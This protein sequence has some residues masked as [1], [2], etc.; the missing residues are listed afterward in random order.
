MAATR[1]TSTRGF[2]LIELVVVVAV[3]AIVTVA[4]AAGVGNI[5][6]ASVQSE[7]GKIAIAVRYLYNLSVLSGKNH[8]LVIDLDTQSYW[9]ESQTTSDP[10]ETF[11][12][13]GEGEEDE[14]AKAVNRPGGKKKAKEAAEADKSTSAGFSPIESR[15]LAKTT[16]DKGVKF[17][18][19]MTSHQQQPTEKGQAYVYFFPNGTTENA[20]IDVKGDEDDVMTVEV[21][22]LQGT[23]TVH[24]QKMDIDKLGKE[25]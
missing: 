25:E 19:V 20:F 5:R 7:T 2:T 15:I 18:S 1:S 11:L 13:P 24:K 17:G 23:A 4:V 21:K 6:G 16:L 10:C 14:A 9:A 8:R 12:L 22:A 3:I